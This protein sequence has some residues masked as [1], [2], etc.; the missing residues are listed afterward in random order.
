VVTADIEES[1]IWDAEKG[2]V[3]TLRW[4]DHPEVNDQAA[5]EAEKGN[6]YREMRKSLD[7]RFIDS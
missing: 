1:W 5:I 2:G 7:K 3:G 6:V 4:M